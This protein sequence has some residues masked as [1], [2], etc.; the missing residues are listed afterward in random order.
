MAIIVIT[1]RD[2]KR[3]Q[4]WLDR[5]GLTSAA[6]EAASETSRTQMRHIRNGGNLTL[7]KMLR[8]LAAAR[9]ISGE[10]VHILDLFDLDSDELLLRPAA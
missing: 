3:L 7:E 6:L 10:P 8:I 1:R 9:L 5:K 2:P 4:R